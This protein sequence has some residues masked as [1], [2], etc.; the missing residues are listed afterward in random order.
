VWLVLAVSAVQAQLS[1]GSLALG[2]VF[3]SSNRGGALEEE[4]AMGRLGF[5]R[6]WVGSVSLLSS[7]ISFWDLQKSCLAFPHFQPSVSSR[8]SIL[9]CSLLVFP[10]CWGRDRSCRRK[11]EEE[12]GRKQVVWGWLREVE[13][14][15]SEKGPEGSG[16]MQQL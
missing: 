11:E 2:T 14:D 16:R 5:C 1:H 3:C 9:P 6:P 7:P 12:E 13:P 8:S 15:P 4:G 10:A